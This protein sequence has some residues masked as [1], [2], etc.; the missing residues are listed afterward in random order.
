MIDMVTNRQKSG[1]LRIPEKDKEKRAVR[2][3][4]E[5]RFWHGIVQAEFS[6]SEGLRCALQV[7]ATKP[8]RRASDSLLRALYMQ[9]LSLSF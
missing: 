7:E 8:A 6:F 1:L 9:P 2:A 5:T 3:T 4:A